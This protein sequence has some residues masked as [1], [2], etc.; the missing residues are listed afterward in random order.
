[1]GGVEVGVDTFLKRGQNA[2]FGI[3]ASTGI[4]DFDVYTDIALR[5]GADFPHVN[6]ATPGQPLGDNLT[7]RFTVPNLSGVVVQAV[8]GI[9]SSR[10]YNDNDMFTVGLEYFYNQAGYTEPEAYAGLIYNSTYVNPPGSTTLSGAGM[11][12]PLPFFYLGRQYGAVF[13]SFPAPYSWN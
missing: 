13:A 8:G 1:L 9:H 7:T 4:W 6:D 11:V 5:A 10:R 3:D 12:Y 2:R